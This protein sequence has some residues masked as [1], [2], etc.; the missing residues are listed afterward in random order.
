MLS[1]GSFLNAYEIQSVIGRGGFGIVYKG[2]H[3]ELGIE[4]AIKEHFP[5][6][7]CVRQDQTV[8]PSK[9]E[10][11]TPF[12]D[13][14][15]R[16]IKEAKQLEKFRE[17]SNIVSCRD[18]FRANGTAYIVMDYV[19]GLPLSVLLEQR[20]SKGNPFTEKDLIQVIIP[21]LKG[22]QIVHELKVYH[23]DI[24]S[25]NILI[26]SADQTPIL[27]DFGAAKHSLSRYTKSLAP[28]SDGYAAMEQVGEGE[29]GPWTDI[30][31]IGAVM[32]RIVAGGASLISSPSP[33]AVQRR[34]YG[35]IQESLDPLPPALDIGQNR[36][37]DNVL[38]AVD[39]CLKINYNDRIQS[40]T[41]LHERII[42]NFQVGT[43]NSESDHEVQS[44]ELKQTSV[45]PIHVPTEERLKT[46]KKDQ[47]S[48]KTKPAVFGALGLMGILIIITGI[49][50]QTKPIINSSQPQGGGAISDSTLDSTATSEVL[51][52]TALAAEE[53]IN[54]SHKQQTTGRIDAHSDDAL[55]SETIIYQST[56]S[57]DDGEYTSGSS[58]PD[59]VESFSQSTQDL[60]YAAE[61]GD[62][63]AQF[64]LGYMYAIGEG[65][66]QNDQEAAKWNRLSAEQGD[67]YAQSLLGYMYRMGAG[68]PQ[69]YQE[70]AK[71]FRLSAE[72]GNASA[73]F[74]LGF[75]YANG[76]GVPQSNQEAVKWYRLS[77][78][79]GF[80]WAQ[81][82]LGHMY[83]KGEGVPQNYQEAAK[84]YLLS[85]EQGNAKAQ[86]TLGSMYALGQGVPEN[87]AVA[88]A[89]VNISIAN[90]F[91][92][93]NV[94]D[95]RDEIR[96]LLTPAQ[97]EEAQKLS[98][99][100][101]NRIQSLKVE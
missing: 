14:L 84:W 94:L 32:W 86:F 74:N 66:P 12:E 93:S 9:P 19:H 99:E 55:I 90:G 30:Y 89:L 27:I 31:G 26:R 5:T 37:S 22:L 25:S 28:Y 24:K 21:L 51:D 1:L 10:F 50:T 38:Q 39:N 48:R 98:A 64:N 78:E 35:L 75:M 71:W 54:T 68:V 29:I 70:A 60:I 8:V 65:V 83:R 2:T 47:S 23:R 20:E 72:Q 57:P 41:E 92:D 13:S 40:C 80:A 62:A 95:I 4:V 18:L 56:G 76:E 85:A 61:Q 101:Y 63:E 43:Q 45:S 59:S 52:T 82:N 3:N 7:L 16:F 58:P 81:F 88:Y 79:Q 15:E 36:F 97:L 6:E 17:H 87:Y 53:P 11:Q 69:S 49:I 91:D 77:A 44:P 34:A 67:A 42:S 73:Q 46:L 100:I 33:I 96:S